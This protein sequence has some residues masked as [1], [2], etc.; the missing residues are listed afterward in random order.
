MSKGYP[1]DRSSDPN[2]V[3]HYAPK[4]ARDRDSVSRQSAGPQLPKAGGFDIATM[5]S[6]NPDFDAER[7]RL[8]GSLEPSAVPEP[9]MREPWWRD[10]ARSLKRDFLLV[11][12]L[13]A[14]TGLV[15]GVGLPS[16]QSFVAKQRSAANLFG[17][18]FDGDPPRVLAESLITASEPKPDN[19]A[20][21]NSAPSTAEQRTAALE[22]AAA[23]VRPTQPA[24]AT[25]APATSQSVN[26]E[27]A[28]AA[29][30]T[31]NVAPSAASVPAASVN[32]VPVQP[33]K[34]VRS[35][36]PDEIT[37]LLKQ[38]EDFV[39]VGDFAS[40]RLVF[41]RVWEADEA[42]GA[43]AFAATYDPIVL[44]RIGAKGATP[45]VAK[46]REW[47]VKAKDLGSP[48]AAPRLEALA[49]QNFA[50]PAQESAAM[51]S[52]G[53]E[54]SNE[55]AS[56][57]SLPSEGPAPAGSYWKHGR[58]IMR[59]EATGLSRKF[60]FYKPS[61]AELEA[62]AKAESLRFDGQISGKGYTGTAFLYSDKCG[63]SAFQ[64]SGQIEN[65]DGRVILSGRSPQV[66]SDCREI[67][68]SDQKLVFDLME[69]P[70]SVPEPEFP[71]PPK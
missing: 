59:L 71:V 40:A 34:P 23:P 26:P 27:P 64:V 6:D 63:R 58:S 1:I 44:A 36:G 49:G 13:G 21:S 32:T 69:T 31:A 35:L 33:E 29:P 9:P 60:F 46:A 39:S 18:R 11:V 2:E 52:T 62:G 65:Y 41:R 66:D 25:P 19:A 57:N 47:Y 7:S 14:L 48:D 30:P 53:R 70:F 37:I 38:G 12:S 50:T 17:A 22:P 56:Q 42:R 51:A 45:D 8:S 61:D 10:R 67:G 3:S 54:A 55:A 24:D 28:I 68:R 43:L 16:I 15:I 20:R 5:A 4:W